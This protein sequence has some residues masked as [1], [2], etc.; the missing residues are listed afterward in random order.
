MPIHRSLRPYYRKDWHALSRKLREE[1]ANNVCECHGL[2]GGHD[3]P[4]G[5]QHDAPHPR[6]GGKTCLTSAH[7]DQDPRDHSPD[8]LCVM[9][10]S[11]HMR[12]DRR[13]EQA[14]R[15]QRIMAEI[16]GQMTIFDD[17]EETSRRERTAPSDSDLRV[18]RNP[19]LVPPLLRP[20]RSLYEQMKQE[21]PITM[22]RAAHIM[23]GVRGWSR[24]TI[25]RRLVSVGVSPVDTTARGYRRYDAI[26]LVEA[27]EGKWPHRIAQGGHNDEA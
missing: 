24:T 10:Q 18:G 4:C 23:Q 9:C 12:Y 11:C 21:T 5:A 25:R 3:G 1:R 8:R 16:L 2:C 26:E 20:T 15:R 7:L 6:T 22:H 13:P 19:S 17:C 14:A 27:V